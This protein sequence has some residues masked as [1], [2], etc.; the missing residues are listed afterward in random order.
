MKHPDFDTYA[1]LHFRDIDR[2]NPNVYGNNILRTEL[3]KRGVGTVVIPRT[4]AYDFESGVVTAYSTVGGDNMELGSQV[5]LPLGDDSPLGVVRARVATPRGLES[6]MPVMNGMKLREIGASKW[7]QYE[8][9]GEYMPRTVIVED[10]QPLND[11]LHEELVGSTLVVKADASQGSNFI[12]IVE[13]TAVTEAISDMRAEFTAWEHKKNKQKVN[14][15]ILVQ[16][17]VPGEPWPELRAIDSDSQFKKDAAQSSELRVYC[18]VDQAGHIQHDKRYYATARSF[19]DGHDEW[20]GVEQ[21]SVS[22]EA[23]RA[24]QEVSERLL[25][26]AAV[27]VGYF[28]VDLIKGR[29]PIDTEPRMYVRE[30]N[31]RDPMMVE[32]EDIPSDALRQRQLLAG[33]MAA[34]AKRL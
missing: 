6:I 8:L 23:W 24:A 12:K 9:A 11:H 27:P 18:Y 4:G 32:L 1:G 17:Y 2:S 25:R 7:K 19:Y 20:V 21:A 5:E 33:A 15:N 10:G 29:S 13:R 16:E 26:Q 34:T 3:G 30:I 22:E 14:K 31:T 28:A